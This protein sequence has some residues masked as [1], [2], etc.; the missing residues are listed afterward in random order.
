MIY[1]PQPDNHIRDKG[2]VVIFLSN[3]ATRKEFYHATRVDTS[4]LAAKKDFIVLQ[5]EVD[6]LDINELFQLV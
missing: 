6:K 5:A 2:K 4:N 1:Y 3:Y